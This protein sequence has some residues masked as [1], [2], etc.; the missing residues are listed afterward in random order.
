VFGLER[1]APGCLVELIERNRAL[2]ILERPLH[3]VAFQVCLPGAL[4]QADEG[5]V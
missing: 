4:Q 3:V 1:E 5:G 2:A